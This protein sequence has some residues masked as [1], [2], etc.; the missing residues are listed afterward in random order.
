MDTT[1]AKIKLRRGIFEGSKNVIFDEGEPAYA[2]DTNRLIIGDGVTP[3]GILINK[4]FY[5]PGPQEDL[6]YYGVAENDILYTNNKIYWARKIDNN[7]EWEDTSIKID[8]N[9]GLRY[10]NDGKLSINYSQPIEYTNDSITLNYDANVLVVKNDGALTINSTIPITANNGISLLYDTQIFKI[11][12][13]NEL[14]LNLVTPIVST[15]NFNNLSSVTIDNNNYYVQLNDDDGTVYTGFGINRAAPLTL[16]HN[17]I[18]VLS[19]A[20]VSSIPVSAEFLSMYNPATSANFVGDD[21]IGIETYITDNTQYALGLDIDTDTLSV[22]P[23]GKLTVTISSEPG[24]KMPVGS[25]IS[26]AS[27]IPPTNWLVC[28]GQTFS[29]TTYPELSSVLGSNIL[30]DLSA[31]FID[32]NIPYIIKAK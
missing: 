17:N 22:T 19:T 30:P 9:S 16:T 12:T 8:E 7:V 24:E 4:N 1:I 2:T 29:E 5:G 18:Y 14:T 26:Y 3:G 11:N 6:E 21:I 10:N 20:A 23:E 28:D 15:N 27:S 13:N 25:I 32:T 31:K